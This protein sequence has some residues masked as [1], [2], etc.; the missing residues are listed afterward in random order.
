MQ[1]PCCFKGRITAGE[2][3][4]THFYTADPEYGSH[5][6]AGLGIPMD[7]VIGKAA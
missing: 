3:Q 2:R 1:L 7:E 5:V 4:V 6:A